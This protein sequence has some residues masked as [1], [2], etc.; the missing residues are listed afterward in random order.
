MA[1]P[2]QKVVKANFSPPSISVGIQIYLLILE[3]SPQPFDQVALLGHSQLWI[4]LAPLFLME[5]DVAIKVAT[6]NGAL[7]NRR[8]LVR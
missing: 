7:Q 5:L 8:C 3:C 6:Y 1:I 4:V 2:L